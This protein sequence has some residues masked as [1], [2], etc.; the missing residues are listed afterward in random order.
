VPFISDSNRALLRSTY[1]SASD[2]KALAI[3]SVQMGFITGQKDEE[4]AKTA[5]VEACRRAADANARQH[6]QIYAVGNVVVFTGGRPLLPPEPWMVR[7]LSTERPLI[8][9]DVPLISESQKTWVDKSYASYR[10]PKALSLMSRGG[11]IFFSG[12]SS[13]DEAVRRSLEWCG[14]I[15]GSPCLVI[16]IDDV[17]VV[18]IPT[19]MKVTGFFRASTDILIASELRGDVARRLANATSGWNVVAVGTNGRP[20]LALR[21]AKEQDG[22]ESALADCNRQDR[23]CRVIAIGPFSVEPKPIGSVEPPP[24]AQ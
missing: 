17:F 23:N 3:S 11:L 9:N 18:T 5:A 12:Q 15:N 7:D 22:M 19:K 2:Y 16:A 13:T 21:A 6:C 8:G 1:I 20:G 14:F 10:K 24:P 4:T